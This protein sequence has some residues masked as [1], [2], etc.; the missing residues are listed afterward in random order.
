MPPSYCNHCP[1]DRPDETKSHNYLFAVSQY[2]H[3]INEIGSGSH[4]SRTCIG[5]D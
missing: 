4:K 1:E 3:K 2:L 5:T